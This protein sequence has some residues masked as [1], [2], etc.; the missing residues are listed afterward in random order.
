MLD[1]VHFLGH[2]SLEVVIFQEIHDPGCL[3][4]L[5]AAHTFYKWL[6]VQ[7]KPFFD[8]VKQYYA[9]FKARKPFS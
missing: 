6:E 8:Q 3:R 1:F 9:C 5:R 7:S 4:F 2:D